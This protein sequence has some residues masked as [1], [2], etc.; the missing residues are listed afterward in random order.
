VATTF[1]AKVVKTPFYMTNDEF[2]RL[3][4][5]HELYP[6]SG[7]CAGCRDV[8]PCRIIRVARAVGLAS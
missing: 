8:W 2:R 1:E 6:G 4:E 3:V 5:G 7:W